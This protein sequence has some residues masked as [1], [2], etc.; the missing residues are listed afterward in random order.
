MPSPL[1]FRS[2]PLVD[3]VHRATLELNPYYIKALIN[4]NTNAFFEEID[5]RIKSNLNI[6]LGIF[7]GTGSGKS[8]CA[9]SIAGRM[10]KQLNTD[11]DASHVFFS[12]TAFLKAMSPD[13][14]DNS[15]Y[16]IDE[17]PKTHGA[18]SQREL[19]NIQNIEE[20]CRKK[21]LNLIFVSPK[22]I[23]HS[24]HYFLETWDRDYAKKV[25]RCV[26]LTTDY[27]PFGWIAIPYPPEQFLKAYEEAKDLNI[28]KTLNKDFAGDRYSEYKDVVMECSQQKTFNSISFKGSSARK[29]FIASKYPYFAK[30]EL[31]E[32][33][34]L[35]EIYILPFIKENPD[36]KLGKKK[37]LSLLSAR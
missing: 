36:K 27:R 9:L 7:G 30:T 34:N 3:E 25:N 6:I 16:I 18:G 31:T 14:P 21:Q 13:I 23:T 10:Q 33:N 8:Y 2:M 24:Q 15:L 28:R 22:P 5:E 20:I 19:A 29:T 32:I 12:S 35:Y 1:N 26:L 37:V 11:F 4:N 17:Q